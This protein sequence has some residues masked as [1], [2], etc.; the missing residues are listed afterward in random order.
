MRDAPRR[1]A[2]IVVGDIAGYGTLMG[3][4][5][6][7]THQR[8]RAIERELIEPT[9]AE[10]RGQIVKTMGDGFLAIFD[11]PVEAVRCALVIQQN[12]TIRNQEVQRSDWMQYRI[13]VN[14]GDVIIDSNDVFGE[15]VNIA[16]RLEQ[17]AEPSTVL[18]SGAIYE[19]VKYKLIAGYQS[20][21]DRRVKHINE[22]VPI[23]RVLPD[24]I[25]FTRA[26]RRQRFR[27]MAISGAVLLILCGAGG[28][29]AWEGLATQELFGGTGLSG[30]PQAPPE[31]QPT[32]PQ[33][34]PHASLTPPPTPQT[35]PQ[36]STEPALQPSAE[37]APQPKQQVAI[38][39]GI[40]NRGSIPE[41][42]APPPVEPV[43]EPDM[44]AIPGGTLLMGSNTDPSEQPIHTVTVKPFR[45]GSYPITVQQW[46]TCVARHGCSD[47]DP[48]TTITDPDTA[49]MTNLSWADAQHYVAW[50]SAASGKTYRLPTEAE[51]EYAAR[52]RSKTPYWWGARM[53]ADVADC[54]GCGSPYNPQQPLPVAMLKPNPFGLF[55]MAG[56][57][58]QWMQ[59]CWHRNYH[60]APQD[61]S[62]WQETD[63]PEHVLRGGS[64]RNGVDDVRVAARDL[65]NTTVR[66]PG[67][68]MRVATS[69]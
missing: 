58:A 16:A 67:H 7:L 65:Y 40:S 39:A 50:L 21:G 63:C 49:P 62:A 56:G 27:T 51:W 28:W 23:Y 37:P 11:S 32:H 33:T 36:P 9:I 14:L 55:D 22:P 64:W 6:E 43:K 61:G 17:M 25:A 4:N 13:G 3:R 18:V 19:Q 26:E 45:L 46:R 24:P 35:A 60:G 8:V 5:E 66:Y 52:A 53:A 20:L 41:Q 10:H 2:A 68:G 31:P 47:V 44:V 12:M 34:Q 59:D 42:P 69:N 1:L 29:F 15:G 30:M 48:E 57:V 54:K 38:V